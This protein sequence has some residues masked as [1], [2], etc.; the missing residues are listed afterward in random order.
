MVCPRH[1]V[2]YRFATGTRRHRGFALVRTLSHSSD[3]PTA[4]CL[5]SPHFIACLISLRHRLHLHSRHWPDPI[6]VLNGSAQQF[7]DTPCLRNAAA[8]LVRRIAAA[9]LGNMT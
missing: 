5:G 6:D 8:W 7:G 9:D 3:S 1:P 2:E 4:D